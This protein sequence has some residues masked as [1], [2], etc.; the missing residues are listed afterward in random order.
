MEGMLVALAYALKG[1]GSGRA[2]SIGDGPA[3]P[4]ALTNLG[5]A[6]P[7]GSIIEVGADAE[8]SVRWRVH[9]NMLESV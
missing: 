4:A 5:F 9:L 7:V 8:S 2:V 6:W 3:S 1:Y